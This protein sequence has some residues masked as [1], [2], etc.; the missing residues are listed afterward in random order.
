M[1]PVPHLGMALS[2]ALGFAAGKAKDELHDRSITEAD[3]MLMAQSGAELEKMFANDKETSQFIENSM[4]QYKT[5][6]NYILTLPTNVSSF[7]DAITFPKSAFRV[8][9]AASSL[10][11]A[12][13]SIRRIA[14]RCRSGWS[15][16]RRYRS[17]TSRRF[18]TR[19]RKSWG[20]CCWMRTTKG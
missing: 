6:T 2:G 19:C 7:D 15:S 14:R 12:L 11:V 4:Q 16:V 5:L 3:K 20:R 13:W 17:N 10:N 18:A 9:Q 1:I 8:Q